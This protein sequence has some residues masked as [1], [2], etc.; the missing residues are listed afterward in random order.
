MIDSRRV[1]S[2]AEPPRWSPVVAR[3]RRRVVGQVRGGRAVASDRAVV[4][5]LVVGGRSE[6][7]RRSVVRLGVLAQRRRMRV[8]LVAAGGAADVR[9]VGRVHVRVLLAI[10]T[11][12]EATSA[13]AV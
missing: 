8:G 12:G 6:S 9:L 7:R 5:R 13:C 11:V 4:V 10:G 1:G 2:F 3:R